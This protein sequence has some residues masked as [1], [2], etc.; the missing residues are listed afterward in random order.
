M[1]KEKDKCVFLGTVLCITLYVISSIYLLYIITSIN[2]VG[3]KLKYLGV[4][5]TYTWGS[6]Y[7]S[8]KMDYL[9]LKFFQCFPDSIS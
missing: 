4:S 2:H 3:N 6:V 9:C 7:N 5:F 8:G 1:F